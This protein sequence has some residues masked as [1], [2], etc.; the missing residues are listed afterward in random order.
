M[1][2]HSSP[3]SRRLS[4][5]HPDLQFASMTSRLPPLPPPATHSPPIP[6]LPPMATHSPLLSPLPPPATH[7]PSLPFETTCLPP[8]PSAT[9]HLPSLRF[10]PPS[11]SP[12][13]PRPPHPLSGDK[14]R[15]QRQPTSFQTARNG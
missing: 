5:P 7:S 14:P 6:P 4:H 15:R 10:V 2:T 8:L 11:I 9:T 13:P 12:L 3:S 1:D